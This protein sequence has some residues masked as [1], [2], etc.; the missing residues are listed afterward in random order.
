MKKK[1]SIITRTSFSIGTILA[2]CSK[3][4]S[5]SEKGGKDGQ[6]Y[7]IKWYTIGTPQKDTD[8]VFAEVNKYLKTKINATVKM[9]QI[10]WGDWD[11]N[12]KL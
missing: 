8:K 2:G 10:D 11:K 12:P 6:P 5:T 4:S 9:Q 3:D 1:I 7:E